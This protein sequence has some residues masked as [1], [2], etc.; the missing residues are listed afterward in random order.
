MH[1]ENKR[2]SRINCF[3]DN[4]ISN[5]YILIPISNF[6]E[7]SG[8]SCRAYRQL[9]IYVEEQEPMTLEVMTRSDGE[10]NSRLTALIF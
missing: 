5:I 3:N 8:F 7:G 2:L 9:S 4:T 10:V 1:S 6:E